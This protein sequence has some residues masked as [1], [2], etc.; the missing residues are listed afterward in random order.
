MIE[1]IENT[2]Q[3][4][5]VRFSAPVFKDPANAQVRFAISAEVEVPVK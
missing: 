2:P 3:F 1:L 5:N 4:K